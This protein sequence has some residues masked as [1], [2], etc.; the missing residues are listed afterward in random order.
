[1]SEGFIAQDDFNFMFQK[2]PIRPVFHTLPKIHKSCV[3]PVPG[4]PIV[5]GIQSLTEAI[6]QYID[7]QIKHLVS[8]LPSFLKDTTDFLNK[9]GA[10]DNIQ[11][12]DFLCSLDIT[13]LYTN[14]P[15]QESL[16]SLSY[17]LN[18]RENPTP[19]TVFLVELTK[20]VLNRNYFKFENSYYLQC[21]GVSMGSPCSPNYANLFMG[22]FEEDFVYNNN[23][24][25]TLIRCWFRFIDDVF[26]IFTG[27][28]DQLQ[29]FK[30]YINSRMQ[31][32]KFTLEHSLESISFLDVVVKKSDQIK[33]D[34]D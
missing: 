17:Y 18:Q 27:T 9:I 33:S 14:V 1:M 5:A 22:K 11:T 24:F 10:I 21:Q 3:E 4:R 31:A 15:N 2:H 30:S 8:N 26:C 19:P 23:P 20:L 25:S 28:S 12:S 13:S 34:S 6:S 7:L 29:E 16:A 32:I